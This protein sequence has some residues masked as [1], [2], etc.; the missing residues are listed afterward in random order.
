MELENLAQNLA[1]RL[2]RL[3][4]VEHAVL[5]EEFSGL[6]A[7]WQLLADRLLDD[8]RPGETDVAARLC[9]QDVSERCERGADAAVG[10]VG[11]ERDE[12]DA[13]LAQPR[14]RL[15]RLRHL[16]ERAAT[17]LPPR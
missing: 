12:E 5:E 9:D 7:V 16:H 2:A 6:K 14:D 10:R 15:A 13:G 8:L 4:D 3:D 17:L 1:Q 11:E